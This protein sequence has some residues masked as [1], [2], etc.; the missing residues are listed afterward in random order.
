MRRDDIESGRTIHGGRTAAGGGSA[1]HGGAMAHG[2]AFG[3]ARAGSAGPA[4][5][6]AETERRARALAMAACHV[7]RPRALDEIADRLSAIGGPE[8]RRAVDRALTGCLREMVGRA[9]QGGWEPADL[10]RVAR[11]RTT[12]G[13]PE[14]LADAMADELAQYASATVDPRWWAQ[15]EQ[16]PAG[17]WWPRGSTPVRARA[18]DASWPVAVRGA[19]VVLRLLGELPRLERL[20]PAPGRY[21]APRRAAATVD[22]RILDRVRALLAKAE[23]TTFEA[24]A[25]TF[26]AGAQALMARHSIDAALLASS[27]PVDPDAPTARRIGIERPYELP[28]AQLL[29]QVADA[30]RCRTV[31]TKDLGFVTVIGFAADLDIVET[32][33]TSLLVQSTSAMTREGRRGRVDGASRTRRFRQSFLYAFAQ[34]VGERLRRATDD[35]MGEAAARAGASGGRE[36]V[37]LMAARTAEVDAAADRLFPEVRRKQLS[38]SMDPEGLA[39]GRLAADRALLEQASPLPRA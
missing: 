32:L 17:C 20:G 7:G 15:M 1:P 10:H 19:V 30:N 6:P 24:E 28:K 36:L 33:F 2:A 4:S 22:S 11:R 16:I 5:D 26:T 38:M 39:S 35:A 14:F 23:S 21:R 13:E 3:G 34:R 12:R 29:T 18:A 25:D 9:W 27:D 37:P 31:W 8:G